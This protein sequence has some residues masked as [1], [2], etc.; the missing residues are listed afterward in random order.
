MKQLIKITIY[1]MYPDEICIANQALNDY[2]RYDRSLPEFC[3]RDDV[4]S[5]TNSESYFQFFT[6]IDLFEEDERKKAYVMFD[7][8]PVSSFIQEEFAHERWNALFRNK[9]KLYEYIKSLSNED[10]LSNWNK[11]YIP[12]D[13]FIMLNMSYHEEGVDIDIVGFLDENFN[14]QVVV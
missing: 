12:Q 5:I 13:V 7:M 8:E 3:L 4:K 10:F 2:K 14:K 11:T 6:D 1:K 9:G